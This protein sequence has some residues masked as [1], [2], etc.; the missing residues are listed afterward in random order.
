[1]SVC[2]KVQELSPLKTRRIK[3]VTNSYAGIMNYC[4]GPAA[5]L[6]NIGL[7]GLGCNGSTEDLTD[8]GFSVVRLSVPNGWEGTSVIVANCSPDIPVLAKLLPARIF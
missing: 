8:K 4:R 1:M 6:D 3:I 5:A 7:H 2:E